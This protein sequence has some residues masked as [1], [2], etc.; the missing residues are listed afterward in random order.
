MRH[1]VTV[2]LI[3][4][5]T[6]L[7]PAVIWNNMTLDARSHAEDRNV[8]T[9]KQTLKTSPQNYLLLLVSVFSPDV[10]SSSR[11]LFPYRRGQKLVLE[12]ALDEVDVREMFECTMNRCLLQSKAM[13]S[14]IYMTCSLTSSC[15]R[16]V[17]KQWWGW[18]G[19]G[20]RQILPLHRHNA[21][22]KDKEEK[23]KTVI[24]NDLIYFRAS[25]IE[26]GYKSYGSYNIRLVSVVGLMLQLK[27]K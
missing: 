4:Y 18:A 14:I 13:P 8:R 2:T 11:D 17:Q 12:E 5:S 6:K 7:Q 23:K 24:W 22:L 9:P 27:K 19:W 25:W 10:E 21:R 15:S 20:W 1:K 26:V 3:Y 16:C